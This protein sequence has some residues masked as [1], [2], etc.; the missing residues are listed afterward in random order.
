MLYGII[1]PIGRNAINKNCSCHV[2]GIIIKRNNKIAKN[3][4]EKAK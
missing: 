3:I 4:Y 2:E 1:K